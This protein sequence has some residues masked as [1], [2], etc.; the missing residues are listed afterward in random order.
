M[1]DEQTGVTR[2][3]LLLVGNALAMPVLLGG[4]RARAEGT[5]EAGPLT[6]GPQIYQSI[7]VEPIINCRGT[8]TIIGGSVER[9]EVRAAMIP[10]RAIS[11]RWTNWQTESGSGW[12]SSR[13]PS[14]AWCRP[15]VRP[16]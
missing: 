8:F 3:E 4:V 15:G 11:C 16:G 10:R 2:R 14:G 5:A 9:P 13:A 12:P 7:G 1:T 6:P